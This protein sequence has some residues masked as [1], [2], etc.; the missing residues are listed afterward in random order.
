METQPRIGIRKRWIRV[1]GVIASDLMKNLIVVGGL[2]LGLGFAIGWVAKPVPVVKEAAAA[3][4]AAQRQASPST[5]TKEA[6]P[7]VQGKRS[8]REPAAPK[9]PHG[10]TDEQMAQAK[11][12]QG[13]MVKQMTKRMR[14]KFEQQIEKLAVSLNLTEDQKKKLTTW[15][16][17]RMKKL[18]GM[19]FEKPE[20][21]GE[22]T[23]MVKTLNNK[24]LQ[25]E[26]APLLSEEQKVALK[27]FTEKE[28]RV[29]VDNTA[30]KNLSKIQ[31]VIELE[32]GQR[33]QVYEILAAGADASVRT[34]ND[35]PD[36][37]SIFMEGMGMDMDPYDLGLQQAMTESVGDPMEFSKKG[38]GQKD[39]AKR[40]R[41]AFDKK[42]DAKVEALK[43]VLNE[44][45]LDQYR[46]ELKT[47]GMGVYGPMLMGMDGAP[48]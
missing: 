28:H 45:Q 22:V 47:K 8:E 46:T 15:L 2:M 41:E 23:G 21:M 12:M 27:D 5:V 33:D 19:D 48:D 11:K 35:N 38:A 24:A 40:L 4:A 6:E 26:L 44:K 34:Q 20:S 13:E 29:K 16:D 10:V 25:E 39:M 30:L 3:N 31:S 42:I 9:N 1:E 36:P 43:P 37:S 17:E 14:T 32:E 7:L 18:D